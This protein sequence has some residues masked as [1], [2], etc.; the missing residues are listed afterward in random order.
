[1]VLNIKSS[2]SVIPV[3]KIN[4]NIS[5]EKEKQIQTQTQPLRFM[6]IVNSKQLV[7]TYKILRVK[8]L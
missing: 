8:R 7:I 6:W 5:I 1:M 2:M 4:W 3:P